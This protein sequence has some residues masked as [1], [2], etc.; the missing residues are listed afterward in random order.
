[1]RPFSVS[2]IGPI[3]FHTSDLPIE[4]HFGTSL[5]RKM[6]FGTTRKG[7]SGDWFDELM[8]GTTSISSNVVRRLIGGSDRHFCWGEVLFA[9]Q[10]LRT[11]H[12][13]MVEKWLALRQYWRNTNT[14][15]RQIW[16][17]P[18]YLFGELRIGV[19]NDMIPMS[20]NSSIFVPHLGL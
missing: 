14:A 2:D 19:K 18:S 5:S 13:K 16:R 1:M 11:Y 15:L 6:T 20:G 12:V 8:W 3:R 9:Y 10:F 4:H 7:R 17:S